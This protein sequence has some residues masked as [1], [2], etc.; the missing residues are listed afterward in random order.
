MHAYEAGASQHAASPGSAKTL[1][2]DRQN[3]VSVQ[4]VAGDSL[5]DSFDGEQP[6][7]GDGPLQGLL[8]DGDTSARHV[9][10]VVYE[11]RGLKIADVGGF[12][13]P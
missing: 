10:V 2:I 7:S 6:L 3:T 5:A 11:A 4:S 9:K 12:S 1:Q 13:D 8:A